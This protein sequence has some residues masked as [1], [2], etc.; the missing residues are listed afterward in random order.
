MNI[1][2]VHESYPHLTVRQ[3]AILI[4]VTRGEIYTTRIANNMGMFASVI[5]RNVHSLAAS[6][7]LTRTEER[8]EKNCQKFRLRLTPVGK[9]VISGLK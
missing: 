2:E 8:G 3:L 6:G 4:A 9:K 5:S 7:L 1:T